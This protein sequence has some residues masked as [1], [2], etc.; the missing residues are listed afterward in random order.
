[1]KILKVVSEA[2]PVKSGIARM[3]G[4]LQQGLTGRGHRVDILSLP[5]IPRLEWGEIRLS[6]MPFKLPALKTRFKAYDLIH[7]HGPVPTFSDVFL[8]AGLYGLGAD[9][10][11]LVYT[12]HAPIELRNFPLQLLTWPYNALQER[13]ARLADHVMVSTPAYG[14]RLA[15]HVPPEKLS[16]IPWGVDYDRFFAPAEKDGPF[17]VLFLGQLRPYKGLNVLLDACAGLN[18]VRLWVIG[19][20]HSAEESR[21]RARDLNLPDVTFWGALSDAEMMW[22]IKQAHVIVLPSVTRSE[23]FGIAL[24]EGMAAGA[25]P[26]ASHL[27]GVA[28]VVGN[29]G[30]TFPVGSVRALR[31]IITR[32]CDDASLRV[33]LA[34]LAQAKARLYSWERVIFGYERVFNRLVSA[35][36]KHLAAPPIEAP[37]PANL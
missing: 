22:R 28:D 30:F 29:E 34:G 17:T 8:L 1:M 16:V 26:V 12:H 5:D 32:L 24:L 27:P 4:K 35:P 14:D 15:R 33:H 21:R 23:A 2:P 36:V 6:S 3:A 18:G 10:P 7:L 11:R 25:V 19:D 20:G 37:R 13:M 9:R 31:E